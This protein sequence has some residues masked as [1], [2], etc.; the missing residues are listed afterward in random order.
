M[1]VWID[2]QVTGEMGSGIYKIYKHYIPEKKTRSNFTDDVINW[3]F[4]K[5]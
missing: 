2:E 4:V 3:S 5:S 1:T